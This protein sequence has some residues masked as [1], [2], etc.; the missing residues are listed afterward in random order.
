MKRSE[1][2]RRPLSDTALANLEPESI[3]YR[4]HDGGGLYFRVR[5]NGSKLWALRYKAPS[6]KWS[7]VGLGRYPAVTAAMARK[8]AA[9]LREQA[10]QGENITGA[11]RLRKQALQEA[12]QNTFESLAEEWL[13]A[14]RPGWSEG[15]YRRVLGALKLH[16]FP[17]M[18]SRPFL[19]IHPM[20][21][22]ELLRDMEKKGILERLR[23]VRSYCKD[24]YDLARV[25]GRITHN[26]LD[27]LNRFLR[28]APAENYAHV[29]Q[30]ELPGLL[31]A[32][33][34]YPHAF[35]IRLGL[36]LLML[37]ASRPSEVREARWEE[38]D[39]E[40]GLWTIPA[41]RMKMRRE[42]LVPLSRQAQEV[43]KELLPLTG[44]YPL[45]FP[46]RND[47][48]KPRS[49][50]VFNMALRRMGYAGRQTGHGFRHIASTILRENGFHRDYVEA[51]LSHVEGGISG[52]YNK[53]TYL[54]QRRE[55]MQWYAD[56][57]HSLKTDS[58]PPPGPLATSIKLPKEPATEPPVLQEEISDA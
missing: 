36:Q 46:G 10:Y 56:Y 17:K 19:D 15:T 45:L 52:V 43:L 35:D 26:P 25:T 50:M 49:N 6:G 13:T 4:E 54:S 41:A 11:A 53:A 39:I 3:E 32:I 37:T 22:M 21:W 30:E 47:R 28:T 23:N 18:G 48:K 16:V 24:I 2:K 57:L 51:Q 14:R 38:F 44:A 42:H 33:S 40:A 5:P 27:G 34:A 12:E 7:W 9:E 31:R 58:P 20:E 8:K 1:I 55:M 29:E